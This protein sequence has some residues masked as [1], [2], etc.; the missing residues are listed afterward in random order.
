MEQREENLWRLLL[1]VSVLFFLLSCTAEQANTTQPDQCIRQKE[2]RNCI[3][4]L[5]EPSAEAV[6]MCEE[7]AYQMAMR[8]TQQ[9]NPSCRIR[10]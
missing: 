4:K 1:M 8:P 9:I 3:D 5:T 2:F 10:N 7:A 6:A